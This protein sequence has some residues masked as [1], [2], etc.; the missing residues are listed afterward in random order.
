MGFTS[1]DGQDEEELACSDEQ[2]EEEITDQDEEEFACSGEGD[3]GDVA[4]SS[5]RDE[6]ESACLDGQDEEEFG[7]SDAQDEGRLWR[8]GERGEEKNACLDRQDDE[9]L[10]CSDEEDDVELLSP[11]EKELAPIDWLGAGNPALSAAQDEEESADSDELV[12]PGEEE[13]GRFDE[14]DE[15]DFAL[16]GDRDGEDPVRLSEEDVREHCCLTASKEASSDLGFS[17]PLT[18]ACAAAGRSKQGGRRT[19]CA[20]LPAVCTMHLLGVTSPDLPF[21]KCTLLLPNGNKRLDCRR[22]VKQRLNLGYVVAIGGALKKRL[23]RL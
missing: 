19:P 6:G 8:S 16:P 21:R 12:R 18:C 20:A 3:D 10:A 1:S 14:Q 17:A 9:E 13:F 11:G 7:L 22:P 23:C 5:G 2:A 15:T 4:R